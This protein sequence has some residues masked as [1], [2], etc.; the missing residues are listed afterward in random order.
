M[1]ERTYMQV[2]P[3]RDHS[4][5]IPRPDLSD[6]LGTPNACTG[7]HR[8]VSNRWAADA[9]RSWKPARALRPHWGS[10]IHAGT[11]GD[12]DAEAKLLRVL[13]DPSTPA[14]ARATAISLLPPYAGPTSG[15]AFEAALEDPNAMVRIEAIAALEALRTP[16]ALRF[17]IP[18]LGDPIRA[19]RLEAA[20]AL[21]AAPAGALDAPQLARRDALLE[22]YRATQRMDADRGEARLRLA[23]LARR[24]GDFE[25][26]ER[27][28]EAARALDPNFVPASVNLA[29][30]Y[31]ALGR[32]EEGEAVL[33]EA[34]VRQPDNPEVHHSLGLVLVRRKQLD[35]AIPSLQRAA[36][37]RPERPR[38]VY[39]YAVALHTAGSDALATQVLREARERHPG[40][41]EIAQLLGQLRAPLED[42]P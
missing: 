24:Q 37:L 20:S 15:A 10:A 17:V 30:L 35:A 31:R 12:A 36:E 29:D 42:G 40:N 19:V 25:Q 22:E 18:L 9:I 41:R 28:L 14:I 16:A 5:R 11:T 33:R 21:A 3:R 23:S 38:Y 39:V 27:E 32:D 1:P 26:A 34:L 8:A 13:A 6:E 4:L 7:C 2:D